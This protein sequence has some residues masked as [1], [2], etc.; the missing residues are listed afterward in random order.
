VAKNPPDGAVFVAPQ[1]SCAAASYSQPFARWGDSSVYELAPD[2]AFTTAGWALA[3]GAAVVGG[4]SPYAPAAAA[5]TRSALI[6]AGGTITSPSICL[7]TSDP[8][9]R[10]FIQGSGVVQAQIVR[11][12]VVMS[13]GVAVAGSRWAPSSAVMTGSSLLGLTPGGTVV[14]NVRITGLVGDPRIDDVWIDPWNRG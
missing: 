2:G 5:N 11:N 9:L 4:G 14:V 7:N 13:S 8:A 3:G 12:G 10:F 1:Q 6:P